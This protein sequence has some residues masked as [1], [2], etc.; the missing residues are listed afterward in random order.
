MSIAAR[1]IV[2]LIV[3]AAAAGC[4]G[5]DT[6]SPKAG[7]PNL[8]V[9][10]N[11][12]SCTRQATGAPYDDG[13]ACGSLDAAW[14]AAQAGDRIQV[15][16]GTYG[17][18]QNIT[19]EKASETTISGENGVTITAPVT[20]ASHLT[21]EN[22]TI[23]GGDKAQ[24]DAFTIGTA[25][26]VTLRQVKV[27]GYYARVVLSGANG[28]KW[29]GGEQ[30][31]PGWTPRKRQCSWPPRPDGDGNPVEI[32]GGKD[33]IIDGVFFAR[34]DHGDFGK[35][36]CPAND[37]FHLEIIRL[38]DAVD[39]FTLR[40][41]YFESNN[42]ANTAVILN[43]HMGGISN[44]VAIVN[45]FFGGTEGIGAFQVAGP[46]S[47]AECKDQLIAYNTFEQGIGAWQCTTYDNVRFVGNVGWRQAFGECAGE[48]AHNVWQDTTS[49][50]CQ[51]TDTWV[52]GARFGLNNLKLDAGKSLGPTAD[53]P[54]VDAAEKPG[55]DAVCTEPEGTTGGAGGAGSRDR[56]GHKRPV[57]AACDAGSL[58][59][60]R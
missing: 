15:K 4:G 22:V 14:D 33:I 29:L 46:E 7:G 34:Q 56:L 12:G 32:D 53:S 3:V 58:E 17:K 13:A 16:A 11:G 60:Q 42:R 21:L 59:L 45:N 28:F 55:G 41:S 20:P 19:G 51:G 31:T 44:N 24:F 6:A 30:G 1:V 50:Q 35:D 37:N 18:P 36:G 40:N 10:T 8:W 2:V 39:G 48:F 23:D 26:D 43:T 49:L 52:Q 57:G 5:G 47:G 27:H 38:Q 54:A 9:D 25:R